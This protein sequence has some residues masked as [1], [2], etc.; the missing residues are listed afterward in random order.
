[1]EASI[2]PEEGSY[3]SPAF[4]H[5]RVSD[6]MRPE[7]LTCPPDASLRTVAATMATEHVHCV[8]I[9]GE[10]DGDGGRAWGLVSALDLVG[11]AGRDLDDVTAGSAAAREFLTVAPD[12]ALE[13]AAQMMLEHRAT[14]LVVVDPETDRPLGVLS[15]LDVAGVLAWGRA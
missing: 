10:G 1:M 14:H 7:V 6:V 11:H 13:R 5:A 3:R 12:E 15:T 9:G 2:T 8:V 4:E